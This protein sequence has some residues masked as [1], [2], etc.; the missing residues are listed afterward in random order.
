MHTQVR[1][2][3]L[4]AG[5]CYAK[6][7]KATVLCVEAHTKEGSVDTQ[8]KGVCRGPTNTPYHVSTHNMCAHNTLPC[9]HTTHFHIQ[10]SKI[11]QNAYAQATH[12]SNKESIT[13]TGSLPL[14]GRH[15]R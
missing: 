12:L 14:V 7:K 15:Q 1:D 9:V 6:H 4:C 2:I 13:K 8:V 10:A 3:V 5:E 11:I